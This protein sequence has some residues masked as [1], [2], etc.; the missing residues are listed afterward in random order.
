MQIWVESV[1]ANY[2]RK[3]L[4]G[5]E[6]TLVFNEKTMGSVEFRGVFNKYGV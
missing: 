1:F 4:N 3:R 6:N 2:F 5:K